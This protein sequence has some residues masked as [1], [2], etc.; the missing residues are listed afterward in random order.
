MQAKRENVEWD[1]IVADGLSYL[2]AMT[3]ATLPT[4][5]NLLL[6]SFR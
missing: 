6:P 5:K 4:K 2:M 3:C 1:G